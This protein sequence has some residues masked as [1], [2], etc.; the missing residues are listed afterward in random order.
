MLKFNIIFSILVSTL[1]IACGGDKS[2]KPTQEPKPTSE[3]KPSNPK[4]NTT[5]KSFSVKNTSI[6]A[7]IKSGSFNLTWQVQS[8]NPYEVDI[9]VS[10]DTFLR[11]SDKTDIRIFGQRCG[12]SS[13]YRCNEKAN[14]KCNFKTDNKITC[15]H[16]DTGK[17][18]SDISSLLVSLPQT[19]YIIIEACNMAYTNCKV[20]SQK[21]KFQ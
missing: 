4:A 2:S 17:D 19:A 18:Q 11:E 9:Y 12:S 6:N 10:R 14:F 16:S 20:K 21:I 3:P 15:A 8:S 1:L 5:I 7:N 13:F